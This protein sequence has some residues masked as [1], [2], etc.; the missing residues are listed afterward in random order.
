MRSNV[1]LRLIVVFCLISGFYTQ[2]HYVSEDDEDDG[3]G[4]PEPT[5]TETGTKDTDGYCIYEE[6]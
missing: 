3:S 4:P 1:W 2:T 5:N 6:T